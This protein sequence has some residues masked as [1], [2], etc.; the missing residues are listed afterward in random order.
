MD[1]A[2]MES[3]LQMLKADYVRVQGDIEKLESVGGNAAAASNELEAI[4]K[5]IQTINQQLAVKGKI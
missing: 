3:K 5:E 1:H 4:E 2:E